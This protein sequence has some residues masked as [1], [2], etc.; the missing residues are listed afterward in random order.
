MDK[1]DEKDKLQQLSFENP[2]QKPET[3]TDGLN[4]RGRK[5]DVLFSLRSYLGSVLALFVLVAEVF[6]KN[7]N[8]ASYVFQSPYGWRC[9][10]EYADKEGSSYY[11]TTQSVEMQVQ[12]VREKTASMDDR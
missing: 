8:N 3:C 4:I 11:V 9:K 1:K 12:K 2:G 7:Y 5:R 10:R 6:S